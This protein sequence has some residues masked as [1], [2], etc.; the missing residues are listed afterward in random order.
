[1]L[2]RFKALPAGYLVILQ[3]EKG[4][5]EAED[6]ELEYSDAMVVATRFN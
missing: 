5:K 1:M 2:K 6:E 3:V 4:M